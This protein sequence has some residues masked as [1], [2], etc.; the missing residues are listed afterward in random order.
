MATFIGESLH[1]LLIALK[2][3]PLV[4]MA[5]SLLPNMAQN[6]DSK[7]KYKVIKSNRPNSRQTLSPGYVLSSTQQKN[8]FQLTWA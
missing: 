1:R 3:G 6:S 5:M 4:M 7:Q 2:I 8:L